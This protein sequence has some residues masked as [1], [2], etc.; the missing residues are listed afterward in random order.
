MSEE[1]K[2]TADSTLP[3]ETS[4][5]PASTSSER[6]LPQSKV[7]E[8]LQTRL[9]EVNEQSQKRQGELEAQNKQLQADLAAA[10]QPKKEETKA[11]KVDDETQRD[12][13]NIKAQLA[14]QDMDLRFAQRVAGMKL[15][16]KQREL[17][18][19]VFET[20]S[21]DSLV[22]EFKI[23]ENP[24]APAPIVALGAASSAPD[25][26]LEVDARRWSK[27]DVSRM[28]SDGTFLKR[29]DQFRNSLPNGA[30]SIP[31]RRRVP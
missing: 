16:D 24:A 22:S 27:D 13:A 25:G 11:P 15:T 30:G 18:R 12:I 7:N 10:Q 17:L 2:D 5:V 4:T 26:A 28:M 29:L 3:V 9:R 1:T 20:D 23:G 21:F 8:I 6:M 19:Q 31:F 14:K